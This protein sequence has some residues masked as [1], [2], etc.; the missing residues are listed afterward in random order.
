MNGGKNVNASFIKKIETVTLN[1]GESIIHGSLYV[2]GYFFLSTRTS[3]AKLLRIN[4]DSISDYQEITFSSGHSYADQI[5]YVESKNKLYVVFGA[6]YRTAIAEVD[7]I[8][9]TYNENAIVDTLHAAS[10]V[11][12]TE[13]G[14]SICNDGSFL[15]VVTARADTSRVLKYSL[16]TMSSIPVAVLNFP[17][18][19]VFAHAIRYENGKLYVT[20]G[21]GTPWVARINASTLQIEEL[22]SFLGMAFT[23]DFAISGNYLFLGIE[24]DYSQ[25]QSGKILRLDKSNFDAYYYFDTGKKG[26]ATAGD[27]YCF[28][29]Q[30]FDGSIWASF[31]TN[32]GIITRINP[33]SLEYQHYSLP[34]NSPNEILYDGRR[35]LITY[36]NQDPGVVQVFHPSWLNAHEI[37]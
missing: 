28:A 17:T 10:P 20:N 12:E 13:G 31:A 27:G 9:M 30:E 37:E 22:H 36:W 25:Q 33:V 29:V 8:M 3:P 32:P 24:A 4:A 35:L 11:F 34:Y 26:S 16:S 18:E 19:N 1:N 14:Q 6:S 23:D 7:P 5:T 15:Y 21:Y 2:N